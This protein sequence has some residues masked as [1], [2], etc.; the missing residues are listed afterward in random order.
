MSPVVLISTSVGFDT[1]Q[2]PE[3]HLSTSSLFKTS[4]SS[5]PKPNTRGQE[6]E[7]MMLK[8]KNEGGQTVSKRHVKPAGILHTKVVFFS[9]FW[10]KCD[11]YQT[12]QERRKVR[13]SLSWA[14]GRFVLQSLAYLLDTDIYISNVQLCTG[15]RLSYKGNYH[16]K[17]RKWKKG[18]K[19]TCP[20]R[21]VKIWPDCNV[22]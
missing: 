19:D 9:V 7:E 4:Q 15:Q 10:C 16:F 1:H 12:W 11:T 18:R 22:L 2:H 5:A 6:W 3:Y 20:C 13:E 8:G 21:S 17:K 14:L